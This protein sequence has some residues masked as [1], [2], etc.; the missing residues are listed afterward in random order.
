M[1]KPTSTHFSDNLRKDKKQQL[2]TTCLSDSPLCTVGQGTLIISFKASHCVTNIALAFKPMGEKTNSALKMPCTQKV[3]N[4]LHNP[5]ELHRDQWVAHLDEQT[6]VS[7]PR[8]LGCE[9]GPLD[10]KVVCKVVQDAA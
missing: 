9:L 4:A 1:V 10:H 6:M 5:H 3:K 2:Y 7:S 8:V